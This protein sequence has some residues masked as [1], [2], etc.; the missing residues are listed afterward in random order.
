MFPRLS[1]QVLAHNQACMTRDVDINLTFGV[2][3]YMIF[4][5]FTLEIKHF[6][7]FTL[8]TPISMKL[9]LFQLTNDTVQLSI[10]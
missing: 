4:L 3:D 1:R 9:N 7:Q 8:P 2:Y 10:T 5:N 6:L